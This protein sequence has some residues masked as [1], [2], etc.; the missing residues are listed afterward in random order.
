MKCVFGFMLM[1]SPLIALVIAGL[2]VG[3][4]ENGWRGVLE[5]L[6]LEIGAG[7]A[8]AAMASVIFYGATLLQ[9][10]GMVK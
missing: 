3:Y 1:G 10:C 2:W 5:M 8:V 7:V 6:L 9:Q 4:R